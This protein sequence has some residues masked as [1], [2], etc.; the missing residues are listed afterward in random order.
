[1][2]NSLSAEF[3]VAADM[4]T[5]AAALVTV[6]VTGS[7][8]EMKAVNSRN[9]DGDGQNVMFG[10]G[11]VEFLQNPFVGVGRDNIYTAAGGS[12]PAGQPFATTPVHANDSVILPT[13]LDGPPPPIIRAEAGPWAWV[14]AAALFATL[15]LGWVF[16]Y[17]PPKPPPLLPAQ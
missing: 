13:I 8:A 17:R 6:P 7:A 16:V 9:H 5:G 1:L 3:A 2:N 11:H 12:V 10:D 4:G 14:A 15:T